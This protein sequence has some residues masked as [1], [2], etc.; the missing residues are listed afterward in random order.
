[1]QAMDAHT[2]LGTALE[3]QVAAVDV[4]LSTAGVDMLSR[5]EEDLAKFVDDTVQM[6]QD[7]LHQPGTALATAL[8]AS[9]VSSVGRYFHVLVRQIYSI[10]QTTVRSSVSCYVHLS[11]MNCGG[12]WSGGLLLWPIC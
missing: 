5:H 4:L 9:V 11:M 8:S 12:R 3:H 7:L 2:S 1:M 6:N 10:T